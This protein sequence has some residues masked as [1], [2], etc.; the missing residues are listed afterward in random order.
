MSAPLTHEAPYPSTEH[1]IHSRLN[2]VV[3]QRRFKTVATNFIGGILSAHD[4]RETQVRKPIGYGYPLKAR[5]RHQDVPVKLLQRPKHSSFPVRQ[6]IP[7]N[8]ESSVHHAKLSSESPG[9]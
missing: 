1:S 2:P 9:T 8:V 4:N 3:I 7:E 5:Q 6:P